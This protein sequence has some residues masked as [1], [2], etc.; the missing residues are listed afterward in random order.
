MTRRCYCCL[1]F[2]YG[3]I[4]S[5]YGNIASYGTND[6]VTKEDFEVNLEVIRTCLKLRRDY[7]NYIKEQ[8]NTN[9][10]YWCSIKHAMEQ[11]N[12]PKK[13]GKLILRTL[14]SS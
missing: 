7:M 1:S 3:I 14:N 2:T 10:N 11:C 4:I 9:D 5:L 12:S 6:S 8:Y 13:Y